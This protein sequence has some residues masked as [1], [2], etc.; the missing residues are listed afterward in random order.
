M[1][2]ADLGGWVAWRLGI[3]LLLVFASQVFL[4]FLGWRLGDRYDLPEVSVTWDAGE[5]A[6]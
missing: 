4:F 3:L 6:E 1:T 2:G 5:N